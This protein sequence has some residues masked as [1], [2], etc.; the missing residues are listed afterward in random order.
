[1]ASIVQLS[2]RAQ[3]I[4][5]N[6]AYTLKKFHAHYYVQKTYSFI[7]YLKGAASPHS[8][9]VNAYYNYAYAQ[10]S[11]CAE[12]PF[13]ECWANISYLLPY[14][15]RRLFVVNNIFFLTAGA[16]F[17]S[18]RQ[19]YVFI[20]KSYTI[21]TFGGALTNALRVFSFR[22]ILAEKRQ[23][24]GRDKHLYAIKK[25]ENIALRITAETKQ[26]LTTLNNG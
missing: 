14:R 7:V 16:S 2:T 26:T 6:C 19:Y 10:D 5:L 4:S 12:Y 23:V 1:M 25:N 20:Y 13:I 11:C 24:N 17:D 9:D 22:N 8:A 3:K 15:H 21:R 18:T